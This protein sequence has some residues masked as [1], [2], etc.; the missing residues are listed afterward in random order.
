MDLVHFLPLTFSFICTFQSYYCVF[1]YYIYKLLV[2]I[3]KYCLPNAHILLLPCPSM[4]SSVRMLLLV[5]KYT[6][7]FTFACIEHNHTSGF[8]FQIHRQPNRVGDHFVFHF[9]PL[10]KCSSCT[11]KACEC[12]GRTEQYTNALTFS[13][14]IVQLC[15]SLQCVVRYNVAHSL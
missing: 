6:P 1:I 9:L 3:S 8:A 7:A 5:I 13:G 10:R 15:M 12:V 14:L 11:S 4:C 2:T